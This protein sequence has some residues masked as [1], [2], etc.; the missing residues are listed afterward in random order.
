[1]KSLFWF[2]VSGEKMCI[3]DSKG[4]FFAQPVLFALEKLLPVMSDE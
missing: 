2:G 1:M 4:K 3:M